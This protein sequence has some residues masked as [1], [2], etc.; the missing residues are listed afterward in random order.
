MADRAELL[1]ATVDCVPE[2][3]AVFG[4]DCQLTIWNQAAQAITVL[5]RMT[6]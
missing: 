5:R 2:G 4:E 1:E 6:W 3:V